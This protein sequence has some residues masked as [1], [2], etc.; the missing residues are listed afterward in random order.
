[1]SIIQILWVKVFFGKLWQEI[2]SQVYI[3]SIIGICR[4]NIKDE[5]CEFMCPHIGG[6]SDS[7]V[8]FKSLGHMV[9]CINCH[10]VLLYSYNPNGKEK[11]WPSGL[12]LNRIFKGWN[13]LRHNISNIY[14]K[15]YL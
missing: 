12:A 1:M 10:T 15:E 3:H 11:E 14:G 4:S 6:I 5:R 7:S 8:M 13:Y 9:P 2:I